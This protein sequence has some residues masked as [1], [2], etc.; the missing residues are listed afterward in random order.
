M[1]MN[2]LIECTKVVFS[3][4]TKNIQILFTEYNVNVEGAKN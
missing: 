1:R 2:I 3:E 4:F